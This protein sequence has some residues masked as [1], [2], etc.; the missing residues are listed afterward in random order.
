MDNSFDHPLFND[1][2]DPIFAID[3]QGNFISVNNALVKMANCPIEKIINASFKIFLP[4]GDPYHVWQNFQKSI[5]GEIL[6]F[7]TTMVD[8]KGESLLVWITN[9]P[10]YQEGKIKGVYGIVKDITKLKD[11]EEKFNAQQQQI[12]NIFESITDAF[13]ALNEDGI[14]NYWNEEAVRLTQ[15]PKEFIIG[16]RL[17]DIFVDPIFEPYIKIYEDTLRDGKTRRF[18]GYFEP[19]GKWLEVA[20][21]RSSEGLSVYFRDI[22]LRKDTE[23]QVL[24]EVEKYQSLFN[25]SPVAKWV[26]DT[27]TLKFLE[28]NK[29]AIQLYGYSREEFL[30]MTIKEI[31][32][33]DDHETIAFIKAAKTNTGLRYQDAVKHIKKDGE[34]IYAKVKGIPFKY[35]NHH[36]RMVA[37]IDETDKVMAKEKLVLNE[38][39]FRALVQE[40]SDLISIIQTDGLCSYISPNSKHI[41]GF[42]SAFL[43][44][45][46]IIEFVHDEDK[47]IILNGLEKI[48]LFQTVK[49]PPFRAINKQGIYIWIEMN[50][51]NLIDDPVIAGYIT[52]ARDI[53]QRIQ[54]EIKIRESMARYDIVSKATSEVIW[55][56]NL[57]TREVIWS[58]GLKDVFG[59]EL[60]TSTETW[61]YNN[62][63]PDDLEKTKENF[64]YI[65]TSLQDKAMCEYR[66]KCADG[67]YSY[68]LDRAFLVMDNNGKPLRMIGSMQDISDRVNYIQSIQAQNNKLMDIAWMQ[69]HK[70]RAP[71]SRIMGL[72]KLIQDS[73]IDSGVSSEVIKYLED[74]ANELDAVIKDIIKQS[75]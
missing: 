50:I 58:P 3:L 37:V 26:Y 46:N 74:S 19:I 49:L 20:I 48:K 39:R 41:L 71:L 17:W 44:R 59:Y 12:L 63:H 42:D 61:W 9:I 52:N 30:N 64:K 56:W 54:D 15:T 36:A 45:K 10:F 25:L 66:F 35:V 51:T 1:Y 73:S 18:E 62:I 22:T 32:S 69:A 21:Y 7:E 38:R 16:K 8:A 65:M 13:L 5:G 40:G 27:Q 47:H 2:P 53:T 70:V 43:L 29:A 55:D 57:E 28:V 11:A 31:L 75:N 23:K 34:I 68:V 67:S 14:V 6:E 4:E 33:P 60:E 72:T 24:V